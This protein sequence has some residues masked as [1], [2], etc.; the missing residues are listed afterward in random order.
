VKLQT[1]NLPTKPQEKKV[2]SKIIE[3]S[4]KITILND[5]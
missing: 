3:E 1:L 4:K 5:G 2:N